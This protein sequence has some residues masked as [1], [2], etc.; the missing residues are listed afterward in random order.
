MI[1]TGADILAGQEVFLK[2]GLMEN[3]SIWGH[4][5]YLGPDFSAEYL[6]TLSQDTADAIAR[7]RYNR[8]WA[9][10]VPTERNAVDAEV[11]QVLKQ[12]R[13]DPNTKNLTFTSAETASYQKQIAK[14]TTYFAQP[15]NDAGLPASYIKDAKELKQLTAFF[16][17]SKR[18]IQSI[19]A[20]CQL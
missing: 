19:S 12:N 11:Q 4:G 20:S 3:G 16:A 10:L 6:H 2:Y 13:Y 8:A 7:Q 14:W 18:S 15:T 1:F 17:S 9:D 5:A